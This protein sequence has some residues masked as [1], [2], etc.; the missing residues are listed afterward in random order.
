MA[1]FLRDALRGF[2][3]GCAL[4]IGGFVLGLADR[5]ALP[6]DNLASIVDRIARPAL[7]GPTLYAGGTIPPLLYGAEFAALDIF[8]QSFVR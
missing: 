6:P 1:A 4:E 7:A 5:L 8:L 3:A 2:F